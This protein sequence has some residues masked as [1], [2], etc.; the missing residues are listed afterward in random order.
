MR[1]AVQRRGRR[2]RI[3]NGYCFGD[4]LKAAQLALRADYMEICFL[5]CN[6][7]KFAYMQSGTFERLVLG[8]IDADIP[9]AQRWSAHE[10]ETISINPRP[11]A[12]AGS[13]C[14]LVASEVSLKRTVC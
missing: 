2:Q 5:T 9:P 13:C 3:A 6:A 8:C 10:I 7:S 4:A 14:T 12:P 1:E 11:V